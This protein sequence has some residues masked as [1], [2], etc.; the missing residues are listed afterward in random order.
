VVGAGQVG[1][2]VAACARVFGIRTLAVVNRVTPNRAED[3]GVEAVFG[4]DQLHYALGLADFVALSTPFTPQTEKM[5]DAAA[6]AAMRP[7]VVL[8]NIAR[9]KVVDE[10]AMI[11]NLRSGHIAFAGLDVAT[12]EPLPTASPLW[13]L[14]NVLICPHSA[15]TAPSENGKIAS[16]FRHNLLAYLDDRRADMINVLDKKR[17]Y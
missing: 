5:I 4:P 11:I 7:G 14:P 16:I 13:D 2:R 8:V 12:M 6:F 17:W 1:A 9:G 10:E 3:L 15:S